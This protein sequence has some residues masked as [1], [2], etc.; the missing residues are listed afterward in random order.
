VAFRDF[1]DD[2]YV[3]E[4]V[5]GLSRRLL[6]MS[7]RSAET[8]TRRQ[9]DLFDRAIEGGDREFPDSPKVFGAAVVRTDEKELPVLLVN[10]G[11]PG[12]EL[13]VGKLLSAEDLTRGRA[14]IEAELGVPIPGAV[15]LLPVPEP[16]PCFAPSEQVRAPVKRGT[17]GARV[18]TAD[19]DDAILTA[20]HVAATGTTVDDEDG[21]PGD[22]VFSVDPGQVPAHTVTAD[23]AVITADCWASHS[24][25][26]VNVAG[27]VELKGGQDVTMHG[28]VSGTQTG[29]VMGRSPFIYVPTMSGQWL[30]CYFTTAGIS[31]DGDSGAP[32]LADGTDDLIGHLVGASGAATSYVEAIDA[33]LRAAGVTLKV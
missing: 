14:G 21:D 31:A 7:R 13:P 25:S 15:Q 23:V 9:Y 4:T 20:G 18:E 26:V 11:L 2:P 28:D 32:V 16:Q 12:D 10:S 19:G 22:V 1:A 3:T 17:L 29:T 5:I 6:A 27:T 24:S 30:D 8:W 33:Q